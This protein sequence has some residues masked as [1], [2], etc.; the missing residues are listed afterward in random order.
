MN[1]LNCFRFLSVPGFVWLAAAAEPA[2]PPT[3]HLPADPACS[4]VDSVQNSLR[5]TLGWTVERDD[6]RHLVSI[7]SFVNPQGE[8][9]GWH[10]FGNLEGPGWAANAVGGA[11]EI[12][13][14]GRF[15]GR[16]SWQADALAILDHVL[17]GGFLDEDTGFIRGYRE[18]TSG[19]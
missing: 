16:A 13:G 7:S 4:I 3:F 11:W 6:R 5:F 15:H 17:D 10:D 19:E 1:A 14:W 8:V 12:W 9:M 18:T 2:A